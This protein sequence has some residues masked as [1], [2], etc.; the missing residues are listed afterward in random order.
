[1]PNVHP[2]ILLLAGS[3]AL[4]VDGVRTEVLKG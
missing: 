4:A 3:H 2:L 1:M